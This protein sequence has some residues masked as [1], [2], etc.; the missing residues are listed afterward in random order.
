MFSLLRKL[1]FLALIAAAVMWYF[2]IPFKGKTLPEYYHGFTDRQDIKEA[3]K[4][5]RSLLGE[6]IKAMGTEI[7]PEH[8]TEEDKKELN[9]VLEKEI[10]HGEP[11]EAE[12]KQIKK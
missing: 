6:S 2:K 11:V 9:E 5:L 10:K 1:I 4:D 8:V 7:T 3:V 12:N